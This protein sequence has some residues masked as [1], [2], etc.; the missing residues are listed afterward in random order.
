MPSLLVLDGFDEVGA[1][2]DRERI[3]DAARDLLRT[4]AQQGASVQVVATTR[5]QGYTGHARSVSA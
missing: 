2:Q 4:L 1:T 5:P 3:V